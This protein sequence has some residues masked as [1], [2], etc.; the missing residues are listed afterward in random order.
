MGI[1]L[2]R[3]LGRTF[4]ELNTEIGCPDVLKNL[5]T[6]NGGPVE[7]GKCL[8]AAFQL[9][10]EGKAL[11]MYFGLPMEKLSRL[12][13]EEDDIQPRAIVGYAGWAAGQLENEI[14]GESWAVCPF[15]PEA[16]L[17]SNEAIWKS[18]IRI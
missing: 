18:L 6:F 2:N 13:D 5:P 14:Q 11:C 17:Q 12:L 15:D 1:V 8:L 3:P 7:P 16:I 9:V 10:D 4:G